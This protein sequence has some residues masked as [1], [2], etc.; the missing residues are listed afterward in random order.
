[1]EA[2]EQI[3]SELRDLPLHDKVDFLSRRN[4]YP[5]GAA[6][7]ATRETHM[8]WV[9]LV[10]DKVYKLKKPVRF[11]YLDFS[12]AAKREAACR[13]E[14]RLNRRL[15]RDIYLDVL[16]LIRSSA[17]ANFRLRPQRVRSPRS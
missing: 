12:S 9:F 16:P 17:M 10:G 7:V 1:M 8:S 4:G 11:P 2:Q 5:E 14:L 6:T 15:A 3:E 13:A